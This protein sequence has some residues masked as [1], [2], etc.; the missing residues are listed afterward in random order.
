MAAAGPKLNHCRLPAPRLCSFLTKHLRVVPRHAGCRCCLR[1]RRSTM[2]FFIP[3]DKN[4]FHS[5]SPPAPVLVL[6]EEK[7]RHRYKA[8]QRRWRRASKTKIFTEVEHSALD[9]LAPVAAAGWMYHLSTANFSFHQALGRN[10][11]RNRNIWDC[12][13]VNS[14]FPSQF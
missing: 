8:T 4:C 1:W 2:F 14:S 5:P 6:E 13:D 9:I 11:A 7:V 12:Q 10:N 3:G